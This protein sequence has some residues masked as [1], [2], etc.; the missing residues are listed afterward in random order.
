MITDHGYKVDADKEYLVTYISALEEW[1][2]SELQYRN[3]DHFIFGVSGGVDSAVIAFLLKRQFKDQTI[4]VMMPSHSHPDDLE[5][6]KLVMESAGLNYHIV[7][8][9]KTH[10][11]LMEAVGD[12]YNHTGDIAKDRVISG[13]NSARLR[14][15]TLYTIAQTRNGIVVGTDNA[16]EW[17]TG[18]FTKFGD[19]GVDI[20]P[21]IHLDKDE[22]FEL[23]RILGV[24]LSIIE[25]KPSAGLWEAQTDEDEMGVTYRALNHHLRG[26]TVTPH[27]LERIQYWHERSH[28]KR[29]MPRFPKAPVRVLD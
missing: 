2:V 10:D 3:A 25:K 11:A 5:D 24:P 23:A 6:A 27:E 26:G 1:L 18:Y 17:Y 16:V 7:D 20:A 9:T 29:A 8:L 19:G 13:N 4:G 21:L 28:H 12:A 14:M 22:I 15:T